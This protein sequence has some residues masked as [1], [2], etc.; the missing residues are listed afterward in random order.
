MTTAITESRTEDTASQG[1]SQGTRGFLFAFVSYLMWGFLPLYMKAVAHIPS[2]EVLAHRIAWSLP[3]AAVLLAFTG[4]YPAVARALRSPRTLVMAAVTASIIAVN[5]LTYVWAI[6]VDRTVETALGYYIN[7]L[8]TVLLAAALLGER[9]SRLQIVAVL[10]AGVAVA[11]L[12]IESGGLPWVSLLLA[13]TFAVYGYLRKTLP[14]GALE[15]FFLEVL[16]LFLP[17]LGYLVWRESQGIGTF[18]QGNGVDMAIL[19]SAGIVTAIP[20]ILYAYGA[21]LLRLTTIGLM[22]YIGPSIIALIA[23]FWF[24]EPF[25]SDRMLAFALIWVA[26]ALYTWTI[27]SGRK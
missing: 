3:V 11:I 24:D 21:K 14:V 12:T 15:G 8:V 7:P 16:L 17:A 10:L 9:L 5:W 2:V 18:G 1:M 20:L 6:S 13:V 25:G 23:V 27:F 22:Q 4:G 26:L 19:A